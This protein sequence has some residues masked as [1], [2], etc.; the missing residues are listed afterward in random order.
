MKTIAFEKGWVDRIEPG[1]QFRMKRGTRNVA[2]QTSRKRIRE[3]GELFTVQEVAD[4]FK[5]TTETIYDWIKKGDIRGKKLKAF[6]IGRHIRVSEEH[7]NEFIG[8]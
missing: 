5:M 2:E 8:A 6:T 7:L 1:T 4:K 3:H